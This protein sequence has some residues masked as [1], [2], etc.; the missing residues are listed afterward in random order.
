M[1]WIQVDEKDVVLNCDYVTHIR[2]EEDEVGKE[3]SFLFVTIHQDY[4]KYSYPAYAHDRLLKMLMDFLED[5]Y[6]HAFA[7][8]K[9]I[10]EFM[11]PPVT[12]EKKMKLI[13]IEKN[14]VKRREK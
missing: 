2:L 5:P 9:A 6:T 8:N 13:P 4:Y 11:M 14:L 10:F 1:K 3:K 7:F 12:G